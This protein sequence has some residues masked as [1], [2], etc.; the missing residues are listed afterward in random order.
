M[1]EEIDNEKND[2]KEKEKIENPSHH[3]VEKD[4]S[5]CK[6]LKE[7]IEKLKMESAGL[8][9][10][11]ASLD[12]SYR[13]KVAEFDNFRKRMTRQIEDAANESKKKFLLEILPIFDNFGRALKSTEEN[14]N[15]DQLFEG[16][17]VTY[18]GFLHFFERLGVKPMDPVGQ[19]FNPNYH[20]AVLMEEK[21]NLPFETTVVDELEKG[22]LMGDMVIRHSKVKVA[23]KKKS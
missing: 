1:N 21:E 17:N 15:F 3:K 7:E 23:K 22:Y 4:N 6:K 16:L 5:E 11:N 19:E 13:R 12:D 14:R 8:L 2:I 20:E 18:N 9:E 10:A